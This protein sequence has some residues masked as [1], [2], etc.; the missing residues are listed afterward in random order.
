MG[1]LVSAGLAVIDSIYVEHCNQF[2]WKTNF[3]IS[4]WSRFRDDI[5]AIVKYKCDK[6]D[7][8]FLL[9]RLQLMYGPQL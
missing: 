7:I 2:L 4:S 3:A 8:Q 9:K 5:L 1:G 6:A